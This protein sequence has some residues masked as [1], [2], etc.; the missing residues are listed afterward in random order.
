MTQRPPAPTT[1]RLVLVADLAG[2][3][4]FALEGALAA[5]AG[6]LDLLGV[7]V[8]AFVTACGGGMIRD[9][10]IG[11][12]PPSALRD[13]RYVLLAILA[14]LAAFAL[15]PLIHES[16]GPLLPVLDALG[17]ALFAVAGTEKALDYGIDPV[18]AVLMGGITAVGGGTL[19]DVLLAEI[20]A[21]LRVDFYASAALAGSAVLV[22]ARRCGLSPPAAA[23]LG[24]CVA[25][26]LRLAAI[27]LHW[28][29][30]MA[31]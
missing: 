25:A 11:A 4:V 22:L 12:T 28:H 27:R 3:V 29:L 10:L 15:H 20:P 8:L 6:H 21:V 14:G 23:L 31:G 2:T 24:G 9:L 30:P 26:A 5:I 1:A 17:L 16:A 18:I 7:L 13:R 19:R